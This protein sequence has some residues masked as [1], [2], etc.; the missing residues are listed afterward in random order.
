MYVR[1]RSEFRGRGVRFKCAQARCSWAQE[2]VLN[3]VGARGRG[4]ASS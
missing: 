3:S 2:T 4:S 1:A